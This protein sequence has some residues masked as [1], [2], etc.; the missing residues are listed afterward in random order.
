MHQ[1]DLPCVKILAI[2]LTFLLMLWK[3]FRKIKTTKTKDYSVKVTPT[4]VKVDRPKDASSTQ[5]VNF[6]VEVLNNGEKVISIGD[7]GF[8]LC[9]GEKKSVAALKD[10]IGGLSFPV[11]LKPRETKRKYLWLDSH[12]VYLPHVEC[13]YVESQDGQ[14]FTGTSPSLQGAI[15]EGAVNLDWA[16]K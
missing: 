16:S 4:S 8:R 6:C 13:V 7:I 5:R 11:Q 9:N 1:S 15:A 2:V 12:L 14:I 3:V 10:T